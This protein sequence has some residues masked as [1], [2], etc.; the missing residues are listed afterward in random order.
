MDVVVDDLKE[1]LK[2]SEQECE[3]EIENQRFQTSHISGNDAKVRFYTGF[4][5]FSALLVC[6]NFLG[7]AVNRLKCWSSTSSRDEKT[8]LKSG[9]GRKRNIPPLEEFFLLFVRLR[10]GLF[11]RD[12]AYRFSISQSTVSRIINTWINLLYLQFK[13][14]PLRPSKAIVTSNMPRVFKNKYPSTRVIIDATEVYVEQPA[15]PELQQLTFSTYKNHN[16]YKGLIGISPSGAVTF[17][18]S[19]YAGSIYV[20][21]DMRSWIIN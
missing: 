17:V 14:I 5:T 10:L 6:F 7:P 20:P 3:V 2:Q 11:E 15:I 13:Q 18:S 19:L 8:R 1:K 9:K 16:T 21:F 4:S 12:L